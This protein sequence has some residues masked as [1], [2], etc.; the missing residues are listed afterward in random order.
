MPFFGRVQSSSPHTGPYTVQKKSN[1]ANQRWHWRASIF[2]IY[3]NNNNC[4]KLLQ[5]IVRTT[6]ASPKMLS[7][8]AVVSPFLHVFLCHVHS[9]VL[10]L[11]EP[12]TLSISV[13]S[14]LSASCPLKDTCERGGSTAG[15]FY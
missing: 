4:S 15:L 9:K 12:P 8:E 2:I 1:D 13:R 11:H 3:Y 5:Y 14:D 10:Q 6:V 7:E